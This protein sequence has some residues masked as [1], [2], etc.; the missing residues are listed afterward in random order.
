M[1][2]AISALLPIPPARHGGRWPRP[3]QSTACQAREI[4]TGTVIRLAAL[5]DGA[6]Q[7]GHGPVKPL[8]KPRSPQAAVGPHP[9]RYIARLPARSDLCRW[10]LWCPLCRPNKCGPVDL[11][12]CLPLR[13]IVACAPAHSIAAWAKSGGL[14]S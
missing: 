8:L 7:L 1:D 6:E 11:G 3:Q 14:A 10:P 9:L 13:K 12:E 5:L 4:G 2:R